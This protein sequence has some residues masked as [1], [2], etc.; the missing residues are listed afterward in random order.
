[1]DLDLGYSSYI[2]YDNVESPKNVQLPKID[3]KEDSVK[4]R[5]SVTDQNMEE[6]LLPTTYKVYKF[7]DALFKMPS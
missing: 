1:M 2:N 7:P 3:M 4:R 6:S 5:M